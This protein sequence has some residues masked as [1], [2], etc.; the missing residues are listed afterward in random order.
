MSNH[1]KSDD[2][3]G[4]PLE[5]ALP[6]DLLEEVLLPDGEPLIPISEKI[7]NLRLDLHDPRTK[8]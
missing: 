5:E 6:P 3:P 4:T 8:R 2:Q 7:N 1:L